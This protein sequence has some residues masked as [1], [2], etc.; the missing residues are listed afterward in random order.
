MGALALSVFFFF[1]GAKLSSVH[2]SGFLSLWVAVFGSCPLFNKKM[3]STIS[4][5]ISVGGVLSVSFL[6]P[7]MSE[8]RSMRTAHPVGGGVLSLN[9][10]R[11]A[12]TVLWVVGG[13]SLPFF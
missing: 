12:P 4:V 9:S 5:S 10:E 13:L 11:Q 2:V 8:V 1:G 7:D 3:Y 6:P